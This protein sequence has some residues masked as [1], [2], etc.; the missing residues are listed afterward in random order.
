MQQKKD[1]E[2]DPN[3]HPPPE[4]DAADLPV[5]YFAEE[6]HKMVKEDKAKGLHDIPKAHAK[7]QA[8]PS[9]DNLPDASEVKVEQKSGSNGVRKLQDSWPVSQFI[10]YEYTESY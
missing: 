8:G 6:I 9:A 4:I 10:N 2:T 1:Y 7:D 5:L 3:A